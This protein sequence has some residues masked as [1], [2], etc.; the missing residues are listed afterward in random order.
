MNRSMPGLPVHHQLP[1][2][3]QTHVHCVGDA[4]QPSHPLLSPSPAFNL[5]QHQGLFKWVSS[6]NQVAKYWSFSFNIS[7][8]NDTY[9]KSNHW[10]SQ[11]IHAAYTGSIQWCAG[12]SLYSL[13][14][15]I[16]SLGF[17]TL[18]SVALIVKLTMVGNR[19]WETLKLRLLV[20]FFVC[21]FVLFC[22][23]WRSSCQIFTSTL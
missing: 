13:V 19:N 4:I 14:R 11:P 9:I 6:P 12:S 15:A 1:K 7:P 18:P 21:L 20:V 17:Q 10:H 23:P 22:F 16:C 5:S 3:T 8:S 2:S